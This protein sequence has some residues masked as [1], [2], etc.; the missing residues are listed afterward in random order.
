MEEQAVQFLQAA[1]DL[2]LAVLPLA[3]PNDAR[4]DVE[5]NTDVGRVVGEFHLPLIY[6]SSR[7]DSPVTA[8]DY[9][10]D[11]AVYI[12]YDL[13]I[14]PDESHLAVE[15]SKFELRVRTT[16]GVRFEFERNYTSAPTAHIHASG[17]SGL[18]SVALMANYEGT[19]HKEKRKGELRELHFPV[20]GRR[21]RPSLEDFLYF[22]IAEC[23]FRGKPGWRELLLDS[24]ETWLDNQLE[25]AVRDHPAVAAE[26]LRQLGYRVEPI[27]GS[28]PPK[29]RKRTW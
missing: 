12:K 4:H 3:S 2:A 14:G 15:R 29:M 23:G 10:P 27:G 9:S 28:D 18:L 21:F 16:P 7:Q 1:L 8:S 11:Y 24:R 6:G 20:G 26:A 22:V 17:V 25:A 19:K 5:L 13:A